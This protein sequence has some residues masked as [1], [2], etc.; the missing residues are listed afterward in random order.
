MHP[1]FA[2]SALAASI[3][4]PRL[5]HGD[6]ATPADS[7][8]VSEC[9]AL[10]RRHAPTVRAASL[11]LAAAR[12]D[13]SA[14]AVNA[15]PTV[16]LLAGAMVAP[17]WSYDPVI[18]NLGDYELK[19]S[20]DWTAADGG[21]LA[22]ARRRGGIDLLA[23]SQRA[24]LE[25]RDV[26][27]E[28]A[29][30][31]IE[32]LRLQEEAAAQR[33]TIEWLDRLTRLVS[34]GVSAGTR[35]PS[36]STRIDLERDAVMS[37]LETTMLDAHT[38]ALELGVL[39]GFGDADSVA[40][41]EAL[42]DADREPSTAD[43]VRLLAFVE[44]MPEVQLAHTL[45]ARSRLDLLDA[46]RAKS[47][48]VSFSVDAGLAGADL[49]HAVPPDLLAQ[50]PG[51]T[52][53]DRLWRDAG[54]SAAVHLR[55]PV[56]DPAAGSAARAREAALGAEEVRSGAEATRQRQGTLALLARWRI[57]YRRVEAAR[58]TNRRAEQNLLRARSLY[59]AGG[60]RLLDLIDAHQ[61]Y[62]EARR[63]LADARAE[64]RLLQFEA[65]D[66]R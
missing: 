41:R 19:L 1:L 28:A 13:S 60:T 35:S 11:D 16:S 12:G 50:Q 27:L 63:R 43:S 56:A 65:E 10:A 58:L 9:V 61:V 46:R 8:T 62:D 18:T 32:L 25:G 6:A 53:G 57:A 3:L 2:R 31:A 45:A 37:A 54:A 33:Q 17:E 29:R 52:F 26:G 59:S 34:A 20:L 64:N 66:R 7:L 36:D 40:V 48:T 44:R 23:A 30:L 24:A 47:P 5:A 15:R 55:L 42:P 38:S 51:A 22:R 4:L 21:R 39:L 49:T 14:A